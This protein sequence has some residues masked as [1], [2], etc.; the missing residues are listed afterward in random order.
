VSFVA[1]E[2]TRKNFLK[3][4]LVVFSPG[5]REKKT[6]DKKMQPNKIWLG[7]YLSR[8]S[9]YQA[10]RILFLGLCTKLVEKGTYKSDTCVKFSFL[11]ERTKIAHI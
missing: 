9:L 1:L 11:L 10:I 8:V 4:C 7:S 2:C 6:R 5:G 3:P